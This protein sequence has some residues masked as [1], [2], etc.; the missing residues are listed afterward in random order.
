MASTNTWVPIIGP[1]PEL[2]AAKQNSNERDRNTLSDL[3]RRQGGR[4]L[5]N[6]Y[7]QFLLNK[8]IKYIPYKIN[9]VKVAIYDVASCASL[10]AFSVT[11]SKDPSSLILCSQSLSSIWPWPANQGLL[12]KIIRLS[13]RVRFALL[14]SLI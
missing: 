11:Y 3:K 6:E 2:T 5:E 9:C 14:L 12:E 7:T 8:L 4:G 1:A 10:I 13:L